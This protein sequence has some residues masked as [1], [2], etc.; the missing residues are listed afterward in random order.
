M[1]KT[2]KETHQ[3]D[4]EEASLPESEVVK[5][6]TEE[7]ES[8]EKRQVFRFTKEQIRWISYLMDKHGNDFKVKSYSGH[9]LDNRICT[10]VSYTHLRAHET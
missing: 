5:S 4:L 8:T 1:V 9:F 3:N 10:P 7:C 2:L 6:L